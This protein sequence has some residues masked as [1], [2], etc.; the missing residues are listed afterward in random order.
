MSGQTSA[1]VTINIADSDYTE[2]IYGMGLKPGWQQFFYPY[3]SIAISVSTNDVLVR[4]PSS[5]HV[6]KGG[7]PELSATGA[8]I[9]KAG[10]SYII[11]ANYPP[12]L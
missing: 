10:E 3:D 4:N 11:K 7:V 9:L 6:T 1:S 12:G 2:I 5:Y 8:W